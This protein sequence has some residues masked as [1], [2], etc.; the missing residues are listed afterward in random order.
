MQNFHEIKSPLLQNCSGDRKG[1]RGPRGL[2]LFRL[3]VK[4]GKV[5][6]SQRKNLEIM[7]PLGLFDL[8]NN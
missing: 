4:L 3:G 2:G 7:T 1:P 6:L 8:L 5:R